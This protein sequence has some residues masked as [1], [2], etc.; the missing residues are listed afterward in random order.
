MRVI[1][2]EADIAIG[3]SEHLFTFSNHGQKAKAIAT[4]LQKG[5]SVFAV[6]QESGIENISDLDNKTYIGY[7]TPL[8]N[9]ILSAMI[10]HGGGKGNFESTTPDRLKVWDAF[11]ENKGD[12]VWI[13]SHWEG[14]LAQ[15]NDTPLQYFYP[16]DFGVPYGYSSVLFARSEMSEEEAIKLKKFLN[17]LSKGYQYAYENPEEEI[18]NILQHFIAHPDYEDAEMLALAFADIKHSFLQNETK[19]WGIMQDSI[20]SNYVDWTIKNGRIFG[21]E[22]DVDAGVFYTNELL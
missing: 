14:V 1:D 16:E 17:I 6:K 5:Q 3:P 21:E 15:L 11:L 19:S 13:F 18:V 4:I 12:I 20:W 7:N 10:K 8:E 9:E 2:R 22:K